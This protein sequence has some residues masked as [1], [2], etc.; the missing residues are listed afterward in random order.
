MIGIG[1]RKPIN[2]IAQQFSWLYFP[3]NTVPFYRVTFLSR[4]GEVTPDSDKYWS[5]LCECAYA[6]YDNNVSSYF[7]FQL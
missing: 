1:L 3:E 2:R 7:I 6:I 4:Y 5:V